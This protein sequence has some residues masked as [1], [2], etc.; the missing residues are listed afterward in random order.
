VLPPLTA[1]KAVE[2]EVAQIKAMMNAPRRVIKAPE[3]APAPAKTSEGTLHKPATAASRARRRMTRSPPWRADKKSI[4]SANVSSTWQDD[5][6]KRG[7]GGMKSRGA[8][9]GGRDG[10]RAGPKGRRHR[11]AMT[12]AKATSRR[13]PK[14]SCKKCTCRKPSPWPIWRTRCPS[15][16]PRSSSS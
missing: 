16:H 4:K 9:G 8:T 13:R 5:A 2:D 6:K 7:T 15:R 14:P 11:M 12:S 1:R 10:W 3:P